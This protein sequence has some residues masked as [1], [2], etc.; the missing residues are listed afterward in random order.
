MGRSISASIGVGLLLAAC[1][2]V[3]AATRLVVGASDYSQPDVSISHDGRVA[4]RES[5]SPSAVIISSDALRAGQATCHGFGEESAAA[6][7]VIIGSDPRASYAFF[8]RVANWLEDCGVR[9]LHIV[10]QVAVALRM[11]GLG[12]PGP[13]TASPEPDAPICP[14]EPAYIS[15]NEDGS[16]VVVGR[17]GMTLRTSLGGLAGALRKAV[18]SDNPTAER[19]LVRADAGVTF[20]QFA[21][22][23]EQLSHDGYTRIGLINEDLSRVPGR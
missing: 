21:R 18:A 14:K 20:A 11:G 15:L 7:G 23:L 16:L 6:R 9:E 10:G 4:I 3:G 12:G 22:A 5:A 17:S 1:P 13:C 19:V 8:M 2:G